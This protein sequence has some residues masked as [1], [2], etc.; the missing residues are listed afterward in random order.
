MFIDYHIC[1]KWADSYVNL[2]TAGKT[3]LRYDV[4]LGDVILRFDQIDLSAKGS[5]IPLIDFALALD[6]IAK[7]LVKEGCP[8]ILEFATLCFDRRG[9][10]L[11]ISAS[12]I[13]DQIEVPLVVFQDQVK[14]FEVQLSKEMQE[15]YPDL[16]RNEAFQGLFAVSNGLFDEQQTLAR[17]SRLR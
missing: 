5:W 14:R 12:Y 15:K 8:A 10:N 3:E 11:V 9:S 13:P 16:A 4:G 17:P 6:D 1:D 2:S 7:R